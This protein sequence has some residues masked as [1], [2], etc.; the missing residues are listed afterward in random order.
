M[1]WY[2]IVGLLLG[3]VG[4]VTGIVSGFITMY[5][6]KSNKDTID[7]SN[8]H[9]LIEEERTER[10][11]LTREYHE[12]KAIVEKKVNEVK[13]EFELLREEN[14]RMLKSIYQGYR[15]KLPEKLSD[16]PVIK[17]FTESG[18]CEDCVKE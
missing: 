4:G 16:C 7:I 2:E 15:C 3:G 6:A 13:K 12:Y 18:S 5:N 14:Q 9:S 11:E 8:F 17:M 1:A 10:K